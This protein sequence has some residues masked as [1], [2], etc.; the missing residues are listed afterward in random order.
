MKK[1]DFNPFAVKWS[2]FFIILV[3]IFICIMWM[4]VSGCNPEKKIIRQD[5]AAVSRVEAKVEL[6]DRVGEQYRQLHKCA[7]DTITNI[8]HDTTTTTL[9]K[10]VS[11]TDTVIKNGIKYIS[12]IDT[13]FFEKEK[14]VFRDRI[15][16]DH[17][18]T[19]RQKDTIISTRLQIATQ[20]GVISEVRTNLSDQKKK[21]IKWEWFFYGS[22][23]L[24]VLSH[25]IRSYI[26][27]WFSSLTGIFKKK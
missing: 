14:T 20:N 22:L 19:N 13:A 18:L 27:G 10:T 11:H 7:N 15:V 16:T 4:F 3:A 21:T 17:E 9:I 23:F 26:G 25:V 2:L 24:L 8:I 1:P 12:L 6:L 5:N